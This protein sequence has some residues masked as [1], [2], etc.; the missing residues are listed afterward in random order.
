MLPNLT[1]NYTNLVDRVVDLGNGLFFSTSVLTT[2]Y[3]IERKKLTQYCVRSNVVEF[4]CLLLP[5]SEN[6]FWSCVNGG[7]GSN[8]P[9]SGAIFGKR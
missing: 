9:T 4:P 1:I 6:F 5:F 2:T 8:G 7:G 3:V